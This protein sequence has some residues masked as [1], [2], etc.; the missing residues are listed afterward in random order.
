MLSKATRIFILIVVYL[1]LLF[2]VFLIIDNIVLPSMTSGQA[3]I[4]VPNVVGI[5]IAAAKKEVL[6]RELVFEIDKEVYNDKVPTG[7]IISQVPLPKSLVK[8]GRFIYVNV[9]KGKEL[10]VVP[11]IKGIISRNAKLKLMKEGL[12]LGVVD[13]EFSEDIGK[14]II[15]YQSK[16]PGEKIPYGSYVNIVVSKGS[17]VQLK[18]PTLIGLSEYEAIYILNELGLNLDR[19]EYKRDNT[20]VPDIVIEQIPPPGTIANQQTII[21]IIVSE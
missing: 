21:K 10:V 19:K 4:P 13:Y 15:I 6:R 1:L 3:T 8:K 14:D 7:K 5:D 9:S 18:V 17:E 20:F 2:F 11:Y 12:E 16:K